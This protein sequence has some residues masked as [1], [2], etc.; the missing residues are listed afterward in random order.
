MF[1]WSKWSIATKILVPFLGLS[2][3]IMA[4]IGYV[5]LSNIR[6]LGIHALETSSTLG[7]SAISD[8]TEALTKLGEQT[9][10]QIASDVAKQV[11]IYLSNRPPHD[12]RRDES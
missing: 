2:I 12:I 7:Q 5:A 10:K 6:I 1:S 9:I 4:I 3:V 11:E 8:S